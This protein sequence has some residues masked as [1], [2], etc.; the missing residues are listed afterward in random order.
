[1]QLMQVVRSLWNRVSASTYSFDPQ[2]A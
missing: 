2:R 1:V